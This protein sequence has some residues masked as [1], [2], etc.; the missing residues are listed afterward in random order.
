MGAHPISNCNIKIKK[1]A[2]DTKQ[3]LTLLPVRYA[4]PLYFLLGTPLML[5]G[6]RG[7]CPFDQ[8]FYRHAF[9]GCFRPQFAVVVPK[10]IYDIII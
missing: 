4:D 7:F 3:T 1:F 9:V 10:L 8:I 6:H 5:V 2:C